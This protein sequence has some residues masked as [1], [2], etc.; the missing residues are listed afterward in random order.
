MILLRRVLRQLG[1]TL[2][3]L[4]V[5]RTQFLVFLLARLDALNGSGQLFDELRHTS[6][7]HLTF[8]PKF[9]DL[10][11]GNLCPVG[12]FCHSGF[13]FTNKQCEICQH[14]LSR[15]RA[16]NVLSLVHF[17]FPQFPI[18]LLRVFL[19]LFRQITI[20]FRDGV[21]VCHWASVCVSLIHLRRRLRGCGDVL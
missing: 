19:D 8:L 13:A 10:R 20:L 3:E 16:Q 12:R 6:F 15:V 11:F 2:F 7:H 4:L 1:V 21:D 14:F 17:L 5:S 18:A 9:D